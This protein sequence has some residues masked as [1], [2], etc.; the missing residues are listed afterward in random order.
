MAS[1]NGYCTVEDVRGVF[2]DAEYSGALAETNNLIVQKAIGAQT[3]WLE[4]A[5]KKH[6]YVSGGLDTDKRGLAFESVKTRDD[7]HS[8]P[9]HGGYVDG[10]Y[11]SDP[12]R[13]TNTSNTVF[14]SQQSAEPDPKK[15]IRLDR[16]DLEDDTVPA[17]TRIQ[18][19]RKDADALNKLSVAN[20]NGGYDDWVASND[21]SGGVG[22][23]SHV[24]D[25]F[26]VRI[27][28]GGVSELYL[29][30][31]SLDDDIA[32]LSN[33][34]LVD[35]DFGDDELPQT[36]RQA[37]AKLSAEWLVNDDEFR[38]MIPDNGQLQGLESK[39]QAWKEQA[40]RSLEPWIEDADKIPFEDL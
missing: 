3:E 20:A 15:Q 30:I 31:H 39:A 1:I 24:G 27:N 4:K 2:Q 19:E 23:D 12:Y 13:A 21:Y 22:F 34:V 14:S 6:W 8:L 38:T 18:L 25:D 5:T 32:Y 37:V 35:F 29:N 17:Y 16:G 33:A 10:A 7:E 36:V 28:S 9:T 40:L 26:Y 11:G